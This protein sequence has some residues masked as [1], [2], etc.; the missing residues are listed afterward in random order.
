MTVFTDLATNDTVH[1]ELVFTTCVVSVSM[2]KPPCGQVPKQSSCRSSV[3]AH[4]GGAPNLEELYICISEISGRSYFTM[5]MH[6]KLNRSWSGKS[7]SWIT[8]LH[9]RRDRDSASS[10]TMPTRNSPS[11]RSNAMCVSSNARTS[12]PFDFDSILSMSSKSLYRST[13]LRNCLRDLPGIASAFY[14][15]HVFWSSSCTAE[16]D[17]SD[18]IPA[19]RHIATCQLR[20]CQ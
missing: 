9:P 15:N 1:D 8:A 13:E 16:R 19:W 3:E 11:L 12:D 4:W 7:T 6:G 5:R 10:K 14:H 18:M 2:A 20:L 17:H